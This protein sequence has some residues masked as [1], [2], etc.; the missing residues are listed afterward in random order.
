VHTCGE[1]DEILCETELQLFSEELIINDLPCYYNTFEKH[2][3]S[4]NNVHCGDLKTYSDCENPL[5][6]GVDEDS[7]GC[8]WQNQQCQTKESLKSES[9]V[10]IMIV[11]VVV[12]VVAVV[13]VVIVIIVVVMRLKRKKLVR[14]A[15]GKTYE[16]DEVGMRKLILNYVYVF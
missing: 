14:R 11:V 5:L 16:M 4:V 6:K 15:D 13:V 12:P 9:A 2:C 7:G 3:A 8:L 10:V 1:L